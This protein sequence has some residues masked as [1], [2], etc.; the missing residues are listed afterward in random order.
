MRHPLIV[1]RDGECRVEVEQADGA[2]TLHFPGEMRE[3]MRFS[4]SQLTMPTEAP[5]APVAASC[6]CG[7]ALPDGPREPTGNSGQLDPERTQGYVE[8]VPVPPERT[9]CAEC[10]RLRQ[11]DTALLAAMKERC[12]RAE[13]ER[14]E[15]QSDRQAM[16]DH[17][18]IM[19]DLDPGFTFQ[20]VLNAMSGWLQRATS[21]EGTV[22]GLRLRN[23]QLAAGLNLPEYAEVPMGWG[24]GFL[25]WGK[26]MMSDGWD[27][28]R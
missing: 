14:N 28:E 5:C 13:A 1:K 20:D 4:R 10:E 9:T 3:P 8:A 24:L 27:G 23:A 12:G 19:L 22:T 25:D 16:D 17:F 11:R 21:T 2:V 15:L 18:R 7:G 26:M 6:D